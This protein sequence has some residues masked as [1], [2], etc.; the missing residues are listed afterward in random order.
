MRMVSQAKLK[1]RRRPNGQEKFITYCVEIPVSYSVF[2]E[3]REEK[4]VWPGTDRRKR[5]YEDTLQL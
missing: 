2:S 4:G 1:D 3:V 5:Y